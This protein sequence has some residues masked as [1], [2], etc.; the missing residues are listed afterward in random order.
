MRSQADTSPWPRDALRRENR[1]PQLSSASS[2]G[3]AVGGISAVWISGPPSSTWYE[4]VISRITPVD[5]RAVTRRV[6]N[7]RPLRTRSTS[8]RI[9]SVWSPE[10]MK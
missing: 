6:R 5:W 1:S 8:K 9:G 10:R 7:E 2:S 4:A 3:G